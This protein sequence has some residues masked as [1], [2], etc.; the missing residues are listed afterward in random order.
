[1]TYIKYNGQ[2]LT[3]EAM[4]SG[5]DFKLNM[6]RDTRV[7]LFDC[8]IQGVGAIGRQVTIKHTTGNGVV[9]LRAACRQSLS[10]RIQ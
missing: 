7:V 8:R 2:A 10:A 1:M 9:I 6:N 5:E 4:A 3:L